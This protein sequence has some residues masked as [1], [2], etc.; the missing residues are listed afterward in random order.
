MGASMVIMPV[1]AGGGGLMMALTNRN[2]L[3]AAAGG[4]FLVAAV[5]VGV[6]MLIG[7]RSGPRRQLREGRERYLDYL[8]E[9]RRTL[10]GTVA[11]QRASARWRH[12]APDRL[13]DLA[14]MHPRRW[15]RRVHDDDFLVLRVG[16]GDR[17]IATRLSMNADDGPLN[18]FDPVCLETA[19]ALRRRY[20]TVRL[21]RPGRARR[22]QR[23]GR[24]GGGPGPGPG[25]GRAAG[26]LPR[27]AGGPAGGGTGAA[28]GRTLGV[29]QVATASPPRHHAGW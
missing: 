2:P 21:P 9:L 3:A 5:A 22:A 10:R 19:Q 8:E 20:S 14:R 17:P 16:I 6:V 27:P 7:Q 18:E 23:G 15:E 24:P 26:D 4:L 12:P 1:L 29:C 28:A 11:A 13:L 25:A